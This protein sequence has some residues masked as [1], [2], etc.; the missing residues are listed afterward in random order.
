[1]STEC[2]VVVLQYV[3]ILYICYVLWD[4]WT[5]VE[6][7]EDFRKLYKNSSMI[8]TTGQHDF[9]YRSSVNRLMKPTQRRWRCM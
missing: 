8:F 7:T 1:M 5:N 2:T 3:N 9:Y 6:L 4:C